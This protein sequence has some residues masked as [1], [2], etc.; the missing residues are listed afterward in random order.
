MSSRTVEPLLGSLTHTTPRK[1][2][3]AAIFSGGCVGLLG[4]GA[5]LVDD[6]AALQPTSLN[7]TPAFWIEVHARFVRALQAAAARGH[8][9]ERAARAR[10]LREFGTMFGGRLQWVGVGGG[11]CPPA[12]LEFIQEAWPDKGGGGGGGSGGGGGGGDGYGTTECG[13][14][15]WTKPGLEGFVLEAGPSREKSAPRSLR[16]ALL[17]PQVNPG[18]L[19]RCGKRT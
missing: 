7:T 6:A 18:S 19:N 1:S 2:M 15:G 17:M 12:V 3:H 4:G 8:E 14:I 5:T 13:S 9:E 16:R 11:A 10:L